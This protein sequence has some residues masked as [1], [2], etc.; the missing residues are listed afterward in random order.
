MFDPWAREVASFRGRE[1]GRRAASPRRRPSSP[2]SSVPPPPRPPPPSALPHTIQL[3][4]DFLRHAARQVFRSRLAG[5]RLGR[6]WMPADGSVIRRNADDDRWVSREHMRVLDDVCTKF[7]TRRFFPD[8]HSRMNMV[9]NVIRLYDRAAKL[10]QP[11][12]RYHVVFKGGVMMRLQ[13]LE[14]LHDLHVEVRHEAIGYVSEHQHAVGVSDFDFE[15]VPDDRAQDESQTWRQVLLN[16]V[17]LL[18]LRR[19][20]EEQLLAPPRARTAE[21]EREVLID[22]T[23]DYGEAEYE[24]RDMLNA[25]VRGLDRSHPL[26]GA[27]VDHVHIVRRGRLLPRLDHRTRLHRAAPSP[28][29]N[30][31]V[32]K[33][34]AAGADETCVAPLAEALRTARCDA[35][36]VALAQGGHGA[37]GAVDEAVDDGGAA[38]YTTTNLHIGEHEPKALPATETSGNFHLS[39]IKHTFVMYY[40]THDGQRRVD[41]LSGEIVDLSQSHYGPLDERKAHMYEDLPSPWRLYPVL[42]DPRGTRIRS[43]TLPALLHDVQD[44]LHHAALP[45]WQNKKAEKR[46][47]RYCLLLVVVALSRHGADATLRAVA[48]LR[49]YLADAARVRGGKMRRTGVGVVDEFADHEHVSAREHAA[50]APRGLVGGHYASLRRHLGKIAAMVDRHRLLASNPWTGAAIVNAMHVEYSSNA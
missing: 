41:R 42:D 49:E 5:R 8:A 46:L 19:Y 47:V 24:L 43:Y 35:S 6:E 32:F 15:I 11:R 14:F 10:L 9:A 3:D 18:W 1:G 12:Q 26:H 28:R 39:R 36:L 7:T 4:E 45:P 17:L 22:N 33:C 23:W 2:S 40:T 38:L 20:L 44:V 29:E 25:E 48:S 31:V 37:R 30:L 27:R 50:G 16:A 21:A 13:L 34:R